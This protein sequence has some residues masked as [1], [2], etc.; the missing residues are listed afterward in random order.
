MTFDPCHKNGRQARHHWYLVIGRFMAG[1]TK[2][3]KGFILDGWTLR[4]KWSLSW[5]KWDRLVLEQGSGDFWP[6]SNPTE[7]CSRWKW[8]FHISDSNVKVDG[9]FCSTR[10][11][12]S[13]QITGPFRSL[14]SKWLITMRHGPWLIYL[15]IRRWNWKLRGKHFLNPN[16]ELLLLSSYS[17]WP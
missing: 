7:P 6:T 1:V 12:R 11:K 10:I 2:V 5:G 17:F 16:P 3:K 15:G 8:T 9:P 13:F 14:P 4:V